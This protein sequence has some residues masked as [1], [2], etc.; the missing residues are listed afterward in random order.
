M[1]ILVV[2]DSYIG[3]R[4]F[5]QAFSR[6]ENDHIVEY[7]QIDRSLAP[8]RRSESERGL[9][10]YEGSPSELVERVRGFDVLVVHGAPVTDEVLAAETLRLVC[11]ARGGPVNVD[12]EAATARGIPVVTTPGKNAVAVAEQT[13]TFLVMLARGFPKAQRFLLEGGRVGSSAFEGAE[14]FGHDLHGHTLGLVGFGHVGKE[15]AP[16]AAAFGMEILIHDPYLG[17]DPPS[18][19]RV[20]SLETLLGRSD[21][22]SLH[23]RAT[24]Q[25]ENLI[26]E[27]EFAAMRPGTFFINTARETLVDEEALAA[28][29]ASGRLAGAALD[30]VRPR[31][32]GPHPLLRFENVVMTPHIGGATYETLLRGAQMIVHEILR[33]DAG[34][35]LQ[36]V[37][38]AAGVRA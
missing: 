21:F 20:A 11:C 1:K 9:R 38:N 15:V 19:E 26:G 13:L 16:R 34:E 8:A 30:V 32:D 28:A 29:L 23:V 33:F 2:G 37:A 27:D 35:P 7:V 5:R 24:P 25:N 18:V 3:P 36:H 6:L 22:V 17:A 31:A 14:F 10:E 4:Y 12:V